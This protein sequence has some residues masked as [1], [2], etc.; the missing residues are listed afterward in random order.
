LIW[1]TACFNLRRPRRGGWGRAG[2]RPRAPSAPASDLGASPFGRR[3]QPPLSCDL[4]L[5]HAQIV[6]TIESLVP[7]GRGSLVRQ[8]AKNQFRSIFQT[9]PLPGNT[10]PASDDADRA[11]RAEAQLAELMGS[12]AMRLVRAIQRGRRV[13]APDHS[14]RWVYLL[15]AS[16]L[17]WRTA[18]R[19][20]SIRRAA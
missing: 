20:K 18:R 7:F 19:L 14:W 5:N 9:P 15:R 16:R 4:R 8:V 12:R 13:V 6:A 2:D 11:V 3:P 10:Q 17:V 1:W